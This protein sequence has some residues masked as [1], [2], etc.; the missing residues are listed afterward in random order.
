M[1]RDSDDEAS[2]R[3]VLRRRIGAERFATWLEGRTRVTLGEGGVEVVCG[4]EFERSL[5][6][7]QLHAELVEAVRES[8][9]EQATV[10]Y[11][12]DAASTPQAKPQRR[13]AA[14]RKR[15]PRSR[16]TADLQRS[17][18]SEPVLQGWVD[19][20]GNAA[21]SG[22]ARRL[23]RGET[24]ASPALLWGPSGV[25]KTHLA[26]AIA[27]G[28]RAT[29]RRKRVLRLGAE[30]FLVAF[31][32][33][34][35]GSGLPSFRHR[36]RGVDLFVLDD[37]QLL[38][39]KRRTA[40]EFRQ[41]LDTLTADGAQVVLTA[42]RGPA[43]LRELGPDLASR[44]AAGVSVEL[45]QPDAPTRERLVHAIA[46]RRAL[47]IPAAAARTLARSLTGGAREV[48]GALNRMTLLH[49]TFDTP[50]DERLAE[51]VAGDLNRLA[52]PPLRLDDIR[53]AVCR[54]C[55]VDA[56]AL[57]S[58]NRTKAVSEPRMLAMWLAR[59]MTP[60]PWSEI[61]DYFGRRS[62]STVIAAHKRVEH[63]LA[64]PE[65]ARVGGCDLGETIRRIEAE[66]R[67]RA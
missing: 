56:R 12:I 8:L 43:E 4:S 35:R 59:R 34:I 31:V 24:P 26:T 55:D 67:A 39:G 6:R 7:E 51:Q 49:E 14:D 44:L 33:A 48:A 22:L 9:G 37:V 46:D 19:W 21:A 62:H 40:E 52:T 16:P 18:P 13:T 58:K 42:D 60:S 23:A 25:G 65:P 41:T 38:L 45:H 20:P 47:T 64:A 57:I 5:C 61:G 27:D 17:A 36:H 63:L 28:V 1:P 29:D 30:R 11:R 2:M 15:L 50:M 66:L 10:R 32:E 53:R 3:E 54:V